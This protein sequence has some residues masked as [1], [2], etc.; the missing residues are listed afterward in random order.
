MTQRLKVVP[1]YIIGYWAG[2]YFQALRHLVAS[3]PPKAKKFKTTFIYFFV[4]PF[5][6]VEDRIMIH[7][8][9]KKKNVLCFLP[10]LQKIYKQSNEF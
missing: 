1:N 7:V 10:I 5:G 6:V 4:S 2:D 8:I 3:L 9:F